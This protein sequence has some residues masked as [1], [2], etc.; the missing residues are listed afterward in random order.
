MPL[1]PGAITSDI[2]ADCV[3]SSTRLVNLALSNIGVSDAVTDLGT[4]ATRNAETARLHYRTE[5]DAVLRAHPWKFATRYVALSRVTGSLAA[6][7]NGD[8][9]Y[10]YRLPEDCLLVRRI[11]PPDGRQRT[12][13]PVPVPFD[14]TEDDWGGLLS[15]NA[16][17]IDIEYTARIACP[18][19]VRDPIFRRACTWRLAHAFA[20][21][22]GRDKAQ[23]EQ[24]YKLYLLQIIEAQTRDQNEQ[25][26]QHP[27]H[28]GEAE[29]IRG[30]E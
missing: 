19:A 23:S 15:A 27:P 24:A 25:Q 9:T 20:L 5:I 22:L 11:V 10:S 14:V 21:P 12:F 16:E 18:A 30:R 28:V 26:A 4:E 7:L 3:A 6:P 17:A 1:D 13:D 29:W 8:W 2:A